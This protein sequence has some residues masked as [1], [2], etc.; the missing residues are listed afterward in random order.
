MN[1][2]ASPRRIALDLRCVDTVE[3]LHAL[4]KIAFAFPSYYGAN[5]DAFWDCLSELP[6]HPMAID[7]YGF[8]D[9]QA[10]L[11]SRIIPFFDVLYDFR[12]SRG[13]TI[14][15]QFHHGEQ[16]GATT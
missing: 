12:Q 6:D 4:L 15:L 11:G 5:W 10:K 16:D 3:E 2:D 13:E 1:T 9:L 14:T 7:V 8:T